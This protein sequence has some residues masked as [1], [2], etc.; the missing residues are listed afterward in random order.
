LVVGGVSMIIAGI[1][2]FIVRDKDDLNIK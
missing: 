1:L 2:N